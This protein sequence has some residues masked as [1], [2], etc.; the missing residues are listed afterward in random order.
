MASAKAGNKM[1]EAL[2]EPG[3]LPCRCRMAVSMRVTK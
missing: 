1:K 2:V 3:M